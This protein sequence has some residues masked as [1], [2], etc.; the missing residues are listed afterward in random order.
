MTL[1][2]DTD[3]E[4]PDI[5]QLA[6]RV[7]ELAAGVAR[8]TADLEDLSAAVLP[9]EFTVPDDDGPADSRHGDRETSVI[10][11]VYGS[12]E[13]WVERYFMPT[14]HRP[15]GGE[16]RWCAHWQ[17][18]AESITRFEALWRS[19]ETLRLEP[20][21][22]MATWLTNFLDPQLAALLGRSGPFAQCTPERHAD[23]VAG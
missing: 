11:P 5:R 13:D 14:F 4:R 1:A 19:W 23:H 10:N 12:L 18:H 22:G 9:D 16:I 3:D 17:K 20:N 15:I 7:D 21:L 2:L 8:L 6:A